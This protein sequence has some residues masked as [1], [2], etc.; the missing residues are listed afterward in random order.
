MPDPAAVAHLGFVFH[1]EDFFIEAVSLAGARDFG[2][3]NDRLAQDEGFPIVDSQHA[4]DIYRAALGNFE[5]FNLQ[6]F[7][8]ADL[9]LFTTGFNYRVNSN[10]SA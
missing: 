5:R 4:F 8:R 9:I 2:A 6:A 7:A 1:P 10:T 3:F